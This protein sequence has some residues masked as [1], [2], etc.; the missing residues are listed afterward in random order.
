MPLCE[1]KDLGGFVDDHYT[2]G[3]DG[4]DG[5]E[6]NTRKDKVKEK[7]HAAS[8]FIL[9]PAN[10]WQDIYFFIFKYNRTNFTLFFIW[11]K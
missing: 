10:G 6:K 3:D 2:K 1:I 4:I 7:I 11:D 9:V 5:T 8:S